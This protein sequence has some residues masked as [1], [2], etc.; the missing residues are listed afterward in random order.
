MYSLRGV[1]GY[2]VCL[3]HR[4]SPVR[5]WTKTEDKF[6]LLL[7]IFSCSLSYKAKKRL[8]AMPLLSYTVYWHQGT[9]LYKLQVTVKSI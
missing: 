5:I 4:R 2:H 6:L 7:Y 9:I 1:V 8:M 3:T